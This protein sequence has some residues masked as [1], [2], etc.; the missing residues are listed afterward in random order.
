MRAHLCLFTID[1]DDVYYPSSIVDAFHAVSGR[2][3]VVYRYVTNNDVYVA[4]VKCWYD[5]HVME[6]GTSRHDMITV[7]WSRWRE[8]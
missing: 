4:H 8:E 3:D 1:R 2:T 7:W 6:I 5:R